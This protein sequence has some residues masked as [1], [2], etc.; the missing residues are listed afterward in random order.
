MTEENEGKWE[1]SSEIGKSDQYEPITD[2]VY[3]L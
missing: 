2:I 1:Y 3:D